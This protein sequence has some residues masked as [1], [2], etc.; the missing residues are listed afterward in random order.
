MRLFGPL[1]LRAKAAVICAVLLAPAFVTGGALVR[2]GLEQAQ[3]AQA[4]R[5]A[6]AVA[7]QLLPLV[8]A[9]QTLQ[10]AARAVAA[11]HE[12]AAADYRQA[13]A[14]ARTAAAALGDTPG[15]PSPGK[16]RGRLGSLPAEATADPALA[17]AADAAATEAAAL[18]P[19]LLGQG[20]LAHDADPEVADPVRQALVALP[21]AAADSASLW[22]WAVHGVVHGAL[23]GPAQYQR[24]AAWQALAKAALA[25]AGQSASPAAAFVQAA[26]VSALV[27][28]AF[29]PDEVYAQGRSALHT[30][31]QQAAAALPVV[32]ARLA[33]RRAERG[34]H[35]ALHAALVAGALLLAAYLFVCFAR[36]LESGFAAVGQELGRIARG[37]LRPATLP[38]GRD[39]AAELQRSAAAARE[40]LRA[41]VDQVRTAAETVARAGREIAAGAG[42]LSQRSEQAAAGLQQTHAALQRIGRDAA[43][44]EQ[45]SGRA[46][47][48]AEAYAEAARASQQTI[49]EAVRTMARV[50]ASA[51]RIAAIVDTIDGIA[52]QTNLLALNAAV[53]AARAGEQGRGFAVVAAEV[54]LLARRSADAAREIKGLIGENVDGV[55][56]GSAVVRSAG[57]RMQAIVGGAGEARALVATIA[58]GAVRQGGEVRHVA[59]ALQALDAATQHNGALVEQT[60]AATAE[61]ERQAYELVRM[62]ARFRTGTLDEGGLE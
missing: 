7:T 2:S 12:A 31:W 45:R 44:G 8:E 36:S 43:D 57:E 9:V 51:G 17:D 53:E 23:D 35:V 26:D 52:F 41:V 48:A 3:A 4:E 14:Q 39:E 22:G 59:A 62:V 24:Q 33:E 20:G 61:L 10:G 27:R 47:V 50:D 18:I 16:L 55:R 60:A 6:L 34:R 40:S 1:R 58:E 42:D 29:T 32:D 21:R 30:L 37:D 13:L 11:G 5:D 28:D 25:D 19:A 56:A 38:A 54:R 46:A 15:A 49:D